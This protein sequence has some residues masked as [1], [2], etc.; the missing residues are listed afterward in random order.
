MSE[1]KL[2]I[3]LGR[4]TTCY[5]SFGIE[6]ENTI[7]ERKS[8]IKIIEIDYD[9]TA[10]ELLEMCY[11]LRD[12]NA[13]IYED[14]KSYFLP[15]F[16]VPMQ[17]KANPSLALK[18]RNS[19]IGHIKYCLEMGLD[20]LKDKQVSRKSITKLRRESLGNFRP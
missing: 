16:I 2:F 6:V 15:L 1:E 11:G 7:K 5:Y 12:D 4:A 3:I 17:E 18:D 19:V 13:M 9:C 20:M 14:F 8:I 10:M